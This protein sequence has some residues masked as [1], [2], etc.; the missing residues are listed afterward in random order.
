MY[1]QV[2]PI[3]IYVK[4][5]TKNNLICSQIIRYTFVSVCICVLNMGGL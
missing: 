1:Q 4:T 3:E 5:T 2:A